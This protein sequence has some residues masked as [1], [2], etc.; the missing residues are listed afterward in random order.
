MNVLAVAIPY[1][2]AVQELSVTNRLEGSMGKQALTFGASK[3]TG[4]SNISFLAFTH[5]KLAR[6]RLLH[7]LGDFKAEA[8]A[9]DVCK[10]QLHGHGESD[11]PGL[12]DVHI[13]RATHMRGHD[14]GVVGRLGVVL[15]RGVGLPAVA[16]FGGALG[17]TCL[18][19]LVVP[20][21]PLDHEGLFQVDLGTLAGFARWFQAAPQPGKLVAAGD[22]M[23]IW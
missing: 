11:R 15:P 5:C 3:E 18:D 17:S 12:G 7:G 22:L 10:A 2:C 23:M 6:S 16:P 13:A 19:A 20:V 1:T 4:K 8:Q 21:A 14:L 9:N